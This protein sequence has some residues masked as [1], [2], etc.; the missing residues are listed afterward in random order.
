MAGISSAMCSS[1]KSE[2]LSAMHCFNASVTQ[3]LSPGN[4][5][6]ALTVNNTTGLAVGMGVSGTGITAGSVI[7]SIDSATQVTLSKATTTATNVP[8]T[9]SGDSFFMALIKQ[10]PSGTYDAST[11]T[12]N[13]LGAD[14]VTSSGTNYV[15]GGKVLNSLTPV[16][17]GTTGYT[18]FTTPLSWTSVTLSTDGA[19]VYNKTN[20]G[21]ATVTNRAVSTHAWGSTQTVSSGSL[22]INFPSSDSANS[23]LRIV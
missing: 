3:T 19:I 6:T 4:A 8:V 22:T 10:A 14:E 7:A 13:S 1:F 2:I 15:T 20:R 16:T 9:F 18:N 21:P 11:T 17:A 23:I 5:V 12:Y